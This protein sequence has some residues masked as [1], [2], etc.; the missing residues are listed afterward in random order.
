M[1]LE[2]KKRIAGVGGKAFFKKQ[3]GQANGRIRLRPIERSSSPNAMKRRK[4]LS[5]VSVREIVKKSFW[6][7]EKREPRES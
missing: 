4:D 7:G 6:R 2:K 1:L 3:G 5:Q